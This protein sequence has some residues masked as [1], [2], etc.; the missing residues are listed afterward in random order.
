MIITVVHVEMT[1]KPNAAPTHSHTTF[2]SLFQNY[3]QQVQVE[4]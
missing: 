1:S 3:N 4:L 2:I